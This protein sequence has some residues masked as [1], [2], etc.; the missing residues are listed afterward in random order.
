M[1]FISISFV[2]FLLA[3][4]QFQNAIARG[5]DWGKVDIGCTFSCGRWNVCAFKNWDNPIGKCG[6]PPSGCECFTFP[7]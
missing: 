2:C 3:V 5:I 4:F 1:K 7:G 6:N